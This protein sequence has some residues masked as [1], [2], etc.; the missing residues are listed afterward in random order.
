LDH[1]RRCTFER[2][3]RALPSSVAD[4]DIKRLCSVA[5]RLESAVRS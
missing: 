3:R 2:L 4:D 1:L 5:S